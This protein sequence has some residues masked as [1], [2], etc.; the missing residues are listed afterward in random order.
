MNGTIALTARRLALPLSVAGIAALGG[1]AIAPAA[2]AAESGSVIIRDGDHGPD[3]FVQLGN[4]KIPVFQ[5]EDAKPNKQHSNCIDLG[6]P[7]R[8]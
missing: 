4:R 3:A 2:S 7:T 1:V 8:F 5:C 6:G